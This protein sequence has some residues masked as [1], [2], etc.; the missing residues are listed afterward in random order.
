MALL[1]LLMK[2]YP[3]KLEAAHLEHGFRGEASMRDADFVREYCEKN[4]VACHIKYGMVMENRLGGESPEMAGRRMR[5]EFMSG[6]AEARGLSFIATGHN[7]GDVVETMLFNLFRGTG[8]EGIAGIPD[9]SHLPYAPRTPIVRP[10][11]DCTRGELREFLAENGV[12]WREDETNDENSYGRNKIRNELLPWVRSN[13]NERADDA[14]L[15]L[16]RE[17]GVVNAAIASEALELLSAVAVPRR[18]A[19]AS[20]S[21]CA[22]RRLPAEKLPYVI[23]AQGKA[24][25]L[26]VLDRRRTLDL[27]GLIL[28][29][30]NWRFQWAGDI[31]AC[32]SGGL[33]G[34]I[35]RR[36]LE[37]WRE[38]VRS[39]GAAAGGV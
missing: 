24:L 16:V 28:R 10:V 36:D 32:A 13:L 35:R 20:W 34:W 37:R 29:S 6:V 17:C 25:S 9:V 12:Q 27:C 7:A 38:Y 15:G 39:A 31:E 33:L 5:Y 14:L 19:L 26:P 3:G 2:F 22:A 18:I 30:G 11:I 1:A 8:L 21:L 4:D 23:R